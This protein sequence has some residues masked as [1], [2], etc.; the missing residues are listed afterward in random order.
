M[1]RDALHEILEEEVR[2]WRDQHMARCREIARLRRDVERARMLA[3]QEM[4]EVVTT[5]GYELE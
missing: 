3:G 4:R 1:T 5:T 2:F